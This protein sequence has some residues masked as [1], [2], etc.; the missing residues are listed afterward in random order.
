MAS[1]QIFDLPTVRLR[2]AKHCLAEVCCCGQI[3]LWEF[4]AHVPASMQYVPNLR[5]LATKLSIEQ[6]LLSA[7]VA[8]LLNELYSTS[9]S[10]RSLELTPQ[11]AVQLSKPL[12]ESTAAELRQSDKLYFYA[13]RMRHA[14]CWAPCYVSWLLCT[15]RAQPGLLGYT[16]ACWACMKITAEPLRQRLFSE[17][18]A[19]CSSKLMPEKPSHG[20]PLRSVGVPR[21]PKA[22]TCCDV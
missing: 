10:E 2:V 14:L 7:N 12:H 22:A 13:D 21:L 16:S 4:A 19:A 3:H 17:N 9:F 6:Q 20:S 11:K 8:G 15:S 18:N 5:A 1:R